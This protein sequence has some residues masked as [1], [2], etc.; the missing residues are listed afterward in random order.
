MSRFERLSKEALVAGLSGKPGEF[1][2]VASISGDAA[3]FL[4]EFEVTEDLDGF[5]GHFPGNPVL[6]GIVQLHWAARCSS[7]LF[8][9]QGE[10]VE[11][12]QLKFKKVVQPPARLSLN[13]RQAAE[14]KVYFEF[15]STDNSH[16][17]GQLIFEQDAL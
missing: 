15:F 12:K 13:L 6:A 17:S 9:Y 8:G 3:E 2:C 14:S 11:I 5:R 10:P 1:P 16:S 4:L 7:H